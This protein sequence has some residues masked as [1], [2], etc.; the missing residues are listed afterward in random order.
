MQQLDRQ[1]QQHMIL[2]DMLPTHTSTIHQCT[3]FQG[4]WKRL[5]ALLGTTIM[6][7]HFK[8]SHLKTLD[9]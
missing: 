5:I 9:S 4:Q 8:D 2:A 1:H 6:H 3:S 7:L